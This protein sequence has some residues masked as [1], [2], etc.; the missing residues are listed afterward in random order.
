M[1]GAGAVAAVCVLGDVQAVEQQL[2]ALLLDERTRQRRMAGAQGLHLVTDQDYPGL[3]SPED[4]VVVPGPPV[5][6]D[7]PAAYFPGRGDPL[8][9]WPIHPAAQ[10]TEQRIQV[11]PT[12]R[13]VNNHGKHIRHFISRH[14]H[15]R[16]ESVG[17]S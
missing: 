15:P 6:G 8:V 17:F 11:W 12:P 2:A 14:S 10:G 5:R 1:E 7:E 3:V 4:R 13:S 9:I 16:Q